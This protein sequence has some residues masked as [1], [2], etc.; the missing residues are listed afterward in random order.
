MESTLVNNTGPEETCF[1]IIRDID[2]VTIFV[3]YPDKTAIKDFRFKK[4]PQG[5]GLATRIGEFLG[6]WKG[7]VYLEKHS[8]ILHLAKIDNKPI[9]IKIPLLKFGFLREAQFK[10]NFPFG[11]VTVKFE[12]SLASATS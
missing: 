1:D 10:Y 12:A 9:D 6:E 5:L 2:C 11:R 7:N 8:P 4:S 3:D